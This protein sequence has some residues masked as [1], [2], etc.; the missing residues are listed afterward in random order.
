MALKVIRTHIHRVSHFNGIRS[1]IRCILLGDPLGF[2]L[3][4]EGLYEDL[5][6]TDI[7]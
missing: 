3:L 6:R 4:S 7:A 2:P 1:S 5:V